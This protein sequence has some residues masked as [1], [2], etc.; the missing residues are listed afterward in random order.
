V[1][2]AGSGPRPRA[3]R[4][5]RAGAPTRRE[6]PDRLVEQTGAVAVL[7]GDHHHGEVVET[8]GHVR[9]PEAEPVLGL[10]RAAP[11]RFGL[12]HG[13][14]APRAV[15]GADPTVLAHRELVAPDPEHPRPR[16]DLGEARGVEDDPAALAHDVRGLLDG[17]ERPG[18]GE[19][20]GDPVVLPLAHHA[21]PLEGLEDLDAVGAD[22]LGHAVVAQ[23]VRRP[24]RV[25]LV[26]APHRGIGVDDAE[27]R[28]HAHAR[29][30][31]HLAG[32]VVG[33]EVAAVIGVAVAR[34]HVPHRERHLVHGILVER[35]G[36]VFGSPRSFSAPASPGEGTPRSSRGTQR[37][38]ARATTDETRPPTIADDAPQARDRLPPAPT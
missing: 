32:S 13:P 21:H 3:T 16:A 29:H 10:G 17:R 8:Q 30:Q 6:D 5:V 19:V 14:D 28:V 26:A 36:H 24:H 27:V 31:E 12:A 25:L 22:A 20:E 11:G 15:P 37:S 33:V 4:A 23:G 7:L 38:P 1:S 34:R 18:P 9:P 35:H 2:R